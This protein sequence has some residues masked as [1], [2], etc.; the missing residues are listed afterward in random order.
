M[1]WILKANADSLAEQI[2]EAVKDG[3]EDLLDVGIKKAFDDFEKVQEN[4]L[5]FKQALKSIT[6]NKKLVIVL[7]ELDRCKPSFALSLLEKVKHVFDLDNLVFIFSTNLNQL[8][9][10]VKKQYG[11]SIDAS[12]YLSKFFN[13]TIKLPNEIEHR[14][15]TMMNSFYLFKILSKDLSFAQD[16]SDSY[17]LGE[18]IRHLF[19]VGDLSLRDTEKFIR[20]IKVLNVVGG[21]FS[22]NEKKLW[23]FST[24]SLISV[25][26]YS[27]KPELSELFLNDKVKGSDISD[28]FEFQ[29]NDIKKDYGRDIKLSTY[30]LFLI[31]FDESYL[32][33]HVGQ[34]RTEELKK[35]VAEIFKGRFGDGIDKQERLFQKKVMRCL[36][37]A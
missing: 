17:H 2:S 18:V 9:S 23:W 26:I 37:L 22:L 25:Y 19:K 8:G 21:E 14:R 27:F 35:I 34:E 24:L 5:V 10:M 12:D 20:N 32:K 7:D 6:D 15:D 3:S 36:Q 33:S 29:P 13:F 11:A 1:S 28:F 30:A 16:L 4:I 31:N